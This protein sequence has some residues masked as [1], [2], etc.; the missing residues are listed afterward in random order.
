MSVETTSMSENGRIVLPVAI[1]RAAGIR[2]K[3]VL[4]VRVDEEGIHLQTR[5]QAILRAQAV[6]KKV[7]GPG[8]SP[9]AELIAERRR[10]AKKEHQGG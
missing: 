2:P 3:E 5:R 4:T 7:F 6:V 10:E 1:R 8:R 9:S